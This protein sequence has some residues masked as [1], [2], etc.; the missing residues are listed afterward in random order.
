[1]VEKLIGEEGSKL[2]VIVQRIGTEP[3]KKSLK[4]WKFKQEKAKK[5]LPL[6]AEDH[7]SFWAIILY[8]TYDEIF[9]LL[10]EHSL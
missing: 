7:G 4:Y 2:I 1:M 9:H 3:F 8:F 6:F 5:L 10:S